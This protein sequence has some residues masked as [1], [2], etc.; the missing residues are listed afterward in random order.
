MANLKVMSVPLYPL[1]SHALGRV[2]PLELTEVSHFNIYGLDASRIPVRITRG[3]K[4]L[5]VL[6][7][8]GYVGLIDAPTAARYPDL[9]RVLDSGFEP[10]CEA[11]IA[12]APDQSG[13]ATVHLSLAPAPFIVPAGQISENAVVLGQGNPISVEL[14]ADFAGACQLLVELQ[15]V[16]KQVALMYNGRLIGGVS[17]PST[18]LLQ[19]AESGDISARLFI[20]GGRGLLD[21][22]VATISPAPPRLLVPPPPLLAQRPAEVPQGELT[23][24]T[25][26][27]EDLPLEPA[28]TRQWRF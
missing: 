13:K 14:N 8:S 11:V 4:G 23:T 3:M 22:S 6:G 19:A 20:A 7:P 10:S 26:D 9:R 12:F 27:C 17:F 15:A 18:A 1:T 2:T 5:P 25:V 16:G 28:S 24:F 21:V